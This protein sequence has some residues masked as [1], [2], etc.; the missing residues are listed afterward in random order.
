MYDA[1]VFPTLISKVTDA[2][3]EQ[4]TECQNRYLEAPY[5]IVYLDSIVVEIYQNGSDI[6]KAVSWLWASI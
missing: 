4:V 5:L 2:V 6:N 1:N 3:K